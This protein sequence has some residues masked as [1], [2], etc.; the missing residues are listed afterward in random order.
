MRINRNLDGKPA[1]YVPVGMHR[2]DTFRRG[3]NANCFSP[4]TEEIA[5]KYE[6]AYM[7]TFTV[8]DSAGSQ[9]SDTVRVVV[10]PRDS[11]L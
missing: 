3:V 2:H 4:Y 5:F 7:I 8:T 1:E 11:M 9:A 6:G 10:T